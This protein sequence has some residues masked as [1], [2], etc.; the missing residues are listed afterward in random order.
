VKVQIKNSLI[1]ITAFSVLC[2]PLMTQSARAA[3]T[4]PRGSWPVCATPTDAYCVESVTLTPDGGKPSKLS[5]GTSGAAAS[6]PD[7][8][9]GK[10]IAGHWGSP[11]WTAAT[12]GAAGYDGIFVDAHQANDYVPWVYVDVQPVLG[13]VLAVQSAN[14]N[15]A[16]NLDKNIAIGIKLHLG[17]IKTGVTFGVGQDVTTV[18]ADSGGLASIVIDG[19][20]TTVPVAGSSK[21]CKG[22]M[23]KAVALVNQFQSVIVPQND[24]LGFGVDGGS[25]NLY[26]GSNGTCTLSTPVWNADTKHFRYTSSAPALSPDGAKTNKGF[27]HAVISFAD[28]KTYWG[29][30]KPQD[31]AQALTVSIITGAGGSTAAIATVSAKNNFITIDTSNFD[32]PDGQLDIALNPTYN[33]TSAGPEATNTSEAAKATANSNAAKA[34]QKIKATVSNTKTITCVKGKLTTKVSGVKPV[35]PKGYTKK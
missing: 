15:Y 3:I 17:T 21:D 12:L 29:L 10:P 31:A 18:I 19:Y 8:T 25:G 22:N 2:M 6:N 14:K 1:A 32:F 24:P 23:G 35:C 27:Y 9:S 7:V 20:P 33:G 16:A 34:N 5:F 13:S 26:V 4:L 11:D 28:A 30:A